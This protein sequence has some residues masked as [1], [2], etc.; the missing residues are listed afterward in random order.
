M[1]I[2]YAK[3]SIDQ[4]DIDAVVKVLK[5]DFITQGPQIP[6]FEKQWIEY[7]KARYA[8]VV[9][10]ATAALHLSVLAL[11]A[12]SDTVVWTSPNSFIASANCALYAG[13][14]IDFV[15][16]NPNTLN[17]CEIAL[18]EKLKK[19]TSKPDIVIPVHFSGQ[20][21][22]MERIYAL[23]QKYGFKIIEDAS[24]AIGASRNGIKVG[25]CQNS[26][27]TVFSLHPAKII[28]S[29]EGGVILLNDQRLYQKLTR[30]RQHG[31]TRDPAHFQYPQMGSWYY[32]QQELGF[33][34]RITDLQC[35]LGSSQLKKA[36]RFV[37]RRAQIAQRY[38]NA[39][40]GIPL[41]LPYIDPENYSSWHLFVVQL[42]LDAISLSHREVF[43]A[44]RSAGIFVNLHYIPIH[45]QPYYQKL[46]FKRGQFPYAENY[47]QRAISLPLFPELKDQ[48]IDFVI[49]KIREIL[50]K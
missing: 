46:G 39:F 12:N 42:Q 4:T 48:E 36:D 32:E 50:V 1:N 49:H 47:Y 10:S 16:I 24:H 44:L 30:L 14:K 34:Y 6:L 15:D 5:G 37:T 22:N 11:D 23:S 33:N 8:L 20:S 38:Q 19:G 13:A 40:M 18:E 17:I 26:E 2:P 9:S 25:A 27:M 28:T 21:P 31:I 43:E 29:G 41:T 7:T 35:A 3:Q 45:L